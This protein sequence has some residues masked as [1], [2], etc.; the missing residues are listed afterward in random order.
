MFYERLD[1]LPHLQLGASAEN[2]A[3]EQFA[4]ITL[5]ATLSKISV[6]SV[7]LHDGFHFV[8]VDSW[9]LTH[10]S[11]FISPPI[12]EGADHRFHVSG[13][14]LMAALLTSL[15]PGIECVGIVSQSGEIHLFRDGRDAVWKG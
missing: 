10:V 1:D 14:R 8:C 3:L 5:T 6:P 11:Q 12:P 13:A 2:V 9:R 15:L 4:D 7:P